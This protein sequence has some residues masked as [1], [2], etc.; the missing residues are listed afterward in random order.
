MLEPQLFFREVIIVKNIITFILAILCAAAIPVLGDEFCSENKVCMI[1]EREDSRVNVLFRNTLP[2]EDQVT[3]VTFEVRPKLENLS[4]PD[5]FP[6]TRTV[7]G[8]QAQPVTT[9]TV[10]DP[11]QRWNTNLYFYWQY[12]SPSAGKEK[13]VSYQLPFEQGKRYRVC[14]SFNGKITHYAETRYA[15]DFLMPIGSPIHAARDGVVVATEDRHGEGKL[16]PAYSTKVNLVYI[17]HDDGSVAR[18]FHLV[19]DGVRV[20][21]GQ[22]VKAHD[23][24]GLS[25][26]SGYSDVP[27]LHFEVS[28]PVNGKSKTTVPFTFVTDYSDHDIPVENGVYSYS[29]LAAKRTIPVSADEI[30]LCRTVK[31]LKPVDIIDTLSMNESANIYI[32]IDLPG[33]HS[34]KLQIY[35]ERNRNQPLRAAWQTGKTWWYTNYEIRG[36]TLSGGPGK[37][38]AEISINN[39]LAKTL[40]FTVK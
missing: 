8:P 20:T 18:Y 2:I 32:P 12:G 13:E 35:N 25:G 9:F 36:S 11:A 30:V 24:I 37:W 22:R 16:E 27:H 10:I 40:E 19:K 15:V 34:I 33:V 21:P 7:K 29:G 6:L 14:Q 3:T 5:R 4:C 26:N 38:K 23:L 39:I 17:Q 31:D 28:R 1:M